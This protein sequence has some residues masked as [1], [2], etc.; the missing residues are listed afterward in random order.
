MTR[1]RITAVLAAVATTSA[2]AAGCGG[3]DDA[4]SSKSGAGDAATKTGG[5][6]VANYTSFPDYMDP[7]LSYTQEGWTALWTVYTPLLTYKHAEGAEGAELVPG[8]AEAMPEISEDGLT[9]TLKLRDGLKYSDGSPVKASDFEHTIKR[10][11]NL[12]SGGIVLL[13]RH[14]RRRGVLRRTARQTPTSPASRP[15]TPPATSRSSSTA[16]DGS[17]NFYLA[18]DFAGLVKG[19]TPV[20]ERDQRSRPSASARSSSRTSSRA[21]GSRS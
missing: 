6:L 11:L 10:V 16:K 9:Y 5:S 21:T 20:R 14:R 17:F 1:P 12:E 3:D 2:F 8:L 13:L 7:A 18:M 15:T 4:S 19:D